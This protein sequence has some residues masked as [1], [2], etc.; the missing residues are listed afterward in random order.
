MYI[1]SSDRIRVDT[2][3]SPTSYIQVENEALLVEVIEHLDKPDLA[4][5]DLTTNGKL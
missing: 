4:L 5:D 2:L 3:G 1:R